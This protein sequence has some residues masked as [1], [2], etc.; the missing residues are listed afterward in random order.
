MKYMMKRLSILCLLCLAAGWTQAQEILDLTQ[1]R[2]LALQYNKELAASLRQSEAAHH[3]MLSYRGNFFPNISLGG[4]AL[5]STADGNI[6]KGE[7]PISLQSGTGQVV[8]LPFSIPFPGI[9]YKLGWMY[10]GRVQF[11]QPIYMGGKIRAAYRM[12]QL[13]E[14]MARQNEKLTTTQVLLETDK[15][16]ALMVKAQEMKKVADKY[17]TLLTELMKNVESAYKH[18]LKSQNDILKVQVKL[19]ESELNI[20]KA[21]NGLRL[22][23]MN[24]CHLIGK[25]L[26]TQLFITGDYPNVTM[27]NLQTDDITARPEYT[28]LDQQIAIAKQQVRLNR[29]EMLPQVGVMGMYGYLHG[30]EAMNQTLFDKASFSV[31]LNVSIPLYHFGE[32]R[33]KVRAAQV[34]LKQAQL[35]QADLHEKMLLELTLAAN[36]LDEARLECDLADRSL[37]Q[38]EEN[39][40]VSGRQYEVGLETLSDHLEAQTLW[41]QAYQTQVEAHFQLYI[42]YV[43]YLKASGSLSTTHK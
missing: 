28:I 13:G 7:I 21:E 32:R 39:R 6:G 1:C 11:E 35:Q 42:Q 8:Q 22:A 24:L 5:Y 33:H 29:S 3:T 30:L 41:Q 18:G 14:A 20:R 40:R 17:H 37:E 2:A 16:Y 36:N 9:D 26:D 10:S 43:A 31:L 19:N 34:K 4:M 23:S 12:S 15:A 38:A 25:P 27:P